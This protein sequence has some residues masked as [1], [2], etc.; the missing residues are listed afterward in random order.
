MRE[1]GRTEPQRSG[2][3][4]HILPH[5]LYQLLG[6]VERGKH[7][8]NNCNILASKVNVLKKILKITSFYFII[9]IIIHN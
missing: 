6:S 4:R 2:V 3:G 8:E 1:C 9:V 7:L 5:E